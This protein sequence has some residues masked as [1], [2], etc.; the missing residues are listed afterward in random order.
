LENIEQVDAV[1]A[2]VILAVRPTTLAAV[3]DFTE[4]IFRRRAPTLGAFDFAE[5]PPVHK[6]ILPEVMPAPL[7]A[8][9]DHR[10]DVAQSKGTEYVA[11]HSHKIKRSNKALERTPSKFSFGFNALPGV[12]QL[13]VLG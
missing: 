9:E 8:V 10:A 4:S 6:G 3:F 2:S 11:V 12:S 5:S 1:N 13:D 7:V